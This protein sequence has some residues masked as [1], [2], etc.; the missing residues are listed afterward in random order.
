MTRLQSIS[1][2]G[3]RSIDRLDDLPLGDLTVL[4]GESGS[5]KTNILLAL[6]LA[7]PHL[8]PLRHLT[9]PAV[10]RQTMSGRSPTFAVDWR[11]TDPDYAGGILVEAADVTSY[12]PGL[13]DVPGVPDGVRDH[14]G[15]WQR[16][17]A[18]PEDYHWVCRPWTPDIAAQ[19]DNGYTPG[20]GDG[21][22]YLRWLRARD[23]QRFRRLVDIVSDYVPH[24]AG[25]D[26][27]VNGKVMELAFHERGSGRLVHWR[28][29]S[30]STLAWLWMALF[31][32]APE[33]S[34]PS[35]LVLDAPDR[36]IAPHGY[37]HL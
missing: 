7:R 3:F 14:V 28:E 18:N 21:I 30:A 23:S 1:V 20:P 13:L 10:M 36:S 35:L 34:S 9:A 2:R 25:I 32:T 16:P 24:I 33:E 8:Q 31:L 5:G 22:V 11:F 6:Q 29:A 12:C 17:P 19:Q 37:A 26:F 4:A 27:A 15:G